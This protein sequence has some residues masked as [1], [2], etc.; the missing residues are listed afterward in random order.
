VELVR[1]I[2]KRD[3][4]KLPGTVKNFV[5]THTYID[6]R[7]VILG[8]KV[9]A[10]NKNQMDIKIKFDNRYYADWMLKCGEQNQEFY[11]QESVQKL[12]DY[13]WTTTRVI[14][15]NLF[16]MYILLFLLPLTV[17]LFT[18]DESIHK[19][20]LKITIPP[21]LILLFIELIQ[22][23]NQGF[24]YFYGWN[25]V[26]FS[27]LLVFSVLQYYGMM[28]QDH[29]KVYMPEMKML[30]ILLSF[31][32]LLF[33]VRIFEEYGFLVQMI[34]LCVSDLIP[35]IMSYMIFLMVFTVC[36]VV[37][38]ME[39]D[40]EVKEVQNLTY[41]Q[42]MFLQTFRTAIGEL[43][44]P[45]YSHIIE[46]PDSFFKTFNISL[47]WICWFSQTFFMLIIMLNFLIAVITSTYE[48]VMN[49]QKIISYMH[50]AELNVENFQLISFFYSLECYRF[51]VFS[52]SKQ[53]GTLED[54]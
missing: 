33:F 21:A 20:M 13:Q 51:I 6:F 34:R 14:M 10:I 1:K 42:M 29:S 23:A 49:Y 41:F 47:I 25:L 8:E 53:V 3:E 46:K 17:T 12:I 44:M 27:L 2:V 35:F 30:L 52:T 24:S 50:K 48:R 26:D 22:M 5:V 54:D 43:G 38:K 45:M 11:L 40:P 32:K 19:A 37:L 18:E 15:T 16:L 7:D 28:N 36:F 39:I 9:R 31:L 4:Q